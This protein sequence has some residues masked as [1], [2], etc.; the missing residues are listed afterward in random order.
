M[1]WFAVT[2]GSFAFFAFFGFGEEA[3]AE[4]KRF[5]AW[6]TATILRQRPQAPVLPTIR[7]VFSCLCSNPH[8]MGL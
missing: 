8:L 4:Y 7:Y 6:F 2:L 1:T 5:F 3:I